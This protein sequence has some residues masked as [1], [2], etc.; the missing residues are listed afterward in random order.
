M[1]GVAVFLIANGLLDVNLGV[2]HRKLV[3]SLIGVA[4]VVLGVL[5]LC[6]VAR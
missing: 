5:V 3:D 4:G 2:S 6:G 1:T